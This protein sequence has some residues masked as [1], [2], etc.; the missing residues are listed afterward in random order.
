MFGYEVTRRR[1]WDGKIRAIQSVYGDWDN[2]YS[3]LP[4]LLNVIEVQNPGTRVV[5][6]TMP[7]NIDGQVIF[8][9]VFW[10]FAHALTLGSIADLS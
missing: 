7:S 6:N 5:W 10:A 1:V 3:M 9:R 2:S 4:H 8:G